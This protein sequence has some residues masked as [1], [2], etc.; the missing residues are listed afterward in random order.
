MILAVDVDYREENAKVSGVCFSDWKSSEYTSLH[1]S[2]VSNVKPYEPGAFYKRELPC[3]LKLIADHQLE[4]SCIVI[5]G[6]VDLGEDNR[7]GLG[8]YLYES[9]DSKIP[10]IGV[11]KKPFK[12]TKT[13]S[14]IYRGES[15]KPLYISSVGILLDEAK[16]LIQSMHGNHRIPY[17]LKLVDRECRKQ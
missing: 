2:M 5:D 7:P 4:L 11:A 3:I 17:L 12:D 8:M 15:K 10:V 13:S 1:H 16:T 9:L 14:E 6:Y